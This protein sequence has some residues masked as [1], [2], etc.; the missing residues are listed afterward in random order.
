VSITHLEVRR[1][2]LWQEQAALEREA[3]IKRSARVGLALI[4]F[5]AL[6]LGIALLLIFLS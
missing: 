3:D 1:H 2:P 4:C 5:G 6:A